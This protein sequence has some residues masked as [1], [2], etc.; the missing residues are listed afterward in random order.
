LGAA[1]CT[2]IANHTSGRRIENGGVG[3]FQTQ[4]FNFIKK[5]TKIT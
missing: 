2:H 4:F 5:I 3:R 1:F